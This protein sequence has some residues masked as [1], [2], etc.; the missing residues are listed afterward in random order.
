MP[1]KTLFEKIADREIPA[2]IVYEDSLCLA[3]ADANPQAPTHLLIIP[4]KEI[5]NN[6]TNYMPYHYMSFLNMHCFFRW[7][8]D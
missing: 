4:K 2:D 3:F 1:E 8:I 6:F 7:D 5:F